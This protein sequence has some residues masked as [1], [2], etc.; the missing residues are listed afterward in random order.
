MLLYELDEI[1][2]RVTVKKKANGSLK[3]NKSVWDRVC[4]IVDSPLATKFTAG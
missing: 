1:I 3:E 4:I 2:Y